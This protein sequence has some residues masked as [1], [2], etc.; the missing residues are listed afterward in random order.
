MANAS[1]PMPMQNLKHMSV[2]NAFDLI[3]KNGKPLKRD[4]GIIC[5]ILQFQF[6]GFRFVPTR[7]LDIAIVP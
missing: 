5:V 3:R 7:L 6:V 2:F 1:K 4:A